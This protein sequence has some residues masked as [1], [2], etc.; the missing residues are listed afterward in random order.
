M[1]F[2]CGFV[3]LTKYWMHSSVRKENYDLQRVAVPNGQQR[4]FQ[5]LVTESFS[6]KQMPATGSQH[7][8]YGK[9]SVNAILV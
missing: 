5:Y 7:E 4:Q 1:I 8:N 9:Y 6:A 2:T 3:E